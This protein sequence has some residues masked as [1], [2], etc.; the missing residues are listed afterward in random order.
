MHRQLSNENIYESLYLQINFLC[1]MAILNKLQ[2][3]GNMLGTKYVQ[4]GTSIRLFQKF[5]PF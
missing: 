2:F 4:I 3:L 1:F 5:C